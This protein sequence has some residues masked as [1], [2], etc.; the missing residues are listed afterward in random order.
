M[1]RA[2]SVNDLDGC[3]PMREL[4]AAV[5]FESIRQR[6]S[7]ALFVSYP[8][9]MSKLLADTLRGA[10]VKSGL[11]ANALA[12]KTGVPQPTITRFLAGADMKLETAGKIAEVLGLRLV[13]VK[14]PRG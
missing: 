9:R 2:E 13:E 11:S 1:H 6:I 8:C 3:Q 10:I 12:E 5:Y 14:R 7:R 4:Y